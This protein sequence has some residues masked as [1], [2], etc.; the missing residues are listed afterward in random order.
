VRQLHQISM[1]RG[2]NYFGPFQKMKTHTRIKTTLTLVLAEMAL[3]SSLLMAGAAA[4]QRSETPLDRAL[5]L[6]LSCVTVSAVHLLPSLTKSRAMWPLWVGCFVLAVYGHA[7]FFAFAGIKAGEARASQSV[8]AQAIKTQQARIT[9][10]LGTIK[11]RP[12]AQV[13]AQL[14]RTT[15]QDRREALAVELSE[16]KRAAALRD[17]LLRLE[18]ELGSNATVTDPVTAQIAS[19]TGANTQAVALVLNLGAAALLELVGM[20]MWIE[21]TTTQCRTDRDSLGD[22]HTQERQPNPPT[23]LE[24]L[25]EAVTAGKCKPTVTGIR[26]FMQCGQAKASE[27]RRELV[28]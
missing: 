24:V 18:A 6:A 26:Q 28:A 2:G 4:W 19:V 20:V 3:G 11:A 5:L 9:D 22:T 8:Q 12:L 15:A 16:A 17:D 23:A 7:G 21:L 25:R 27:L 10:T 14:S 1:K 13:A